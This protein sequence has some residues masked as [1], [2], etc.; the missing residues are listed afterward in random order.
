MDGIQAMRRGRGAYGRLLRQ[1]R[2]G[3]P[4]R[5]GMLGG[6]RDIDAQAQW[7]AQGKKR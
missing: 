5:Q 1:V 4:V 2:Q 6:W 3:G 7:D